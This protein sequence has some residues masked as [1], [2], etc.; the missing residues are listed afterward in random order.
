VTKE[1]LLSLYQAQQNTRALARLIDE[2]APRRIF[3][4]GLAGS[5]G[6]FIAASVAGLTSR[7]HVFILP[8]REDAA[9]FLNNLEQLL[10]NPSALFFP[11]SYKKPFRL[12]EVDNAS[13]L[14]RAEALNR[15]N[16]NL[17]TLLV[18]YPEAV[19]EKVATRRNLEQNSIEL[20]VGDKVSTDFLNEFLLH[21]EFENTDF[22]AEA[23]E[24]SVRGG[25]V[26]V[27]SFSNELPYRIEFFGDEV[28]SIRTFDP[29]NQ[30]SVTAMNHITLL[31][32]VQAGRLK[33]SRAAFFDFLPAGACLWLSDVSGM[34]AFIES[35]LAKANEDAAEKSCSSDALKDVFDNAGDIEKHLQRFHTLESGARG[36]FPPDEILTWNTTPQPSFNKNFELLIGNLQDNRAKGYTNLIFADTAKQSERL[37]AIFEDLERN[38]AQSGMWNSLH[39][40]SPFMKVLST[41]T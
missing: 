16:R 26:D 41:M 36:Y 32:N 14:L 23:G 5:S 4:Q 27:F 17:Q 3:M 35:S 8:N 18:T 12:D 13:V 19:V 40:C 11:S 2:P 34:L 15:L 25:I 33:E 22:V 39:S 29:V 6:A 20:R 38:K 28:E 1:E 10:P 30:L 9:Y 7:Q 21:H 37:Y 31:P 24:Y